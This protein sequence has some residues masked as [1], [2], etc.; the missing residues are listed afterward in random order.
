MKPTTND[1]PETVSIIYRKA[2]T[3]HV[4]TSPDLR[5]LHVGHQNLKRAFEMI[6]EAVS[7]V[8]ELTCGIEAEYEPDLSYDEFRSRLDSDEITCQL[9]VSLG[10]HG[11]THN[12]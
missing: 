5:G 9:T 12:H 6:P 7:G 11:H 2:G 1:A 10:H 4:F 3:V 8:V